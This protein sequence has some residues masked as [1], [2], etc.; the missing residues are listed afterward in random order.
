MNFIVLHEQKGPNLSFFAHACHSERERRISRVGSRNPSM[1]FSMTLP[2]GEIA[3]AA[4]GRQQALVW[5]MV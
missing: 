4:P 5:L 2:K 1:M 3:F